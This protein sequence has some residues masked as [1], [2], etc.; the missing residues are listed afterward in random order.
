MTD[1]EPAGAP[2]R[3]LTR[4]LSAAVL[5]GALATPVFLGLTTGAALAAQGQ[6]GGP[7]V[8]LNPGGGA[9]TDGSD[10][11][12]VLVNVDAEYDDPGED[13]ILYRDEEQ[14]CCGAAA[15]SLTIGGQLVGQAGAATYNDSLDWDSVTLVSSS[16]SAT[17]TPEGTYTGSSAATTGDGSAVLRYSVTLDG[18][19]YTLDRTLSYTF[20]ND[21]FTDAYSVTIP[22][23]N[24]LPVVLNQGGD[25]S[26]G[27]SDRGYGILL[28]Q[29]A[30]SVIS[31]NPD[32]GV[33]LGYRQVPTSAPFDGATSQDYDAP[34]DAVSAGEDI[35][36]TVDTALHDAG[37]MIQWDLGSAP[38]TYSRAQ[39][40][41]V[42]EQGTNLSASFR[43]PVAA[44]GESTLLD[45]DIVNTELT[46]VD[47]VGFSFTLP[48][49]LTL[50]T[51]A[52]ANSCGGTLTATPGSSTVTFTSGAVPATANCVISVP[53]VATAA[54]TYTITPDAVTGLTGLTSTVGTASLA[55]EAAPGTPPTT[56]PVT[57]APV[58]TTPVAA[59]PAGPTLANT[60]AETGPALALAGGLLLV[61][62]GSL[63][64]ARKRRV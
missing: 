24:T 18:L 57:A 30:Y 27:G 34:Y 51:D 7:M 40:T 28:T 21:Y 39:E 17:V 33:L 44:V 3:R 31:L 38:G 55:V 10:G 41:F 19:T 32:A 9:L 23:G 53:V 36:F 4:R 14:Y 52:P 54:G 12:H 29:P 11:L 47:G 42:N 58:A 15:P 8:E 43:S 25:T 63:V 22:T 35:G 46:A 49:G 62:A 20:P 37:L 50:G 6:F 26:P 13:Q 61:G 60:G 16:G 64:V 48:A 56:T 2:A 1:F 45:F 5:A 59:A